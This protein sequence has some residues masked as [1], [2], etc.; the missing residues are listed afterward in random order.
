[1]SIETVLGLFSRSVRTLIISVAFEAEK[2]L[3]S[4]RTLGRFMSVRC[5]RHAGPYGPEDTFF[6]R[7]RMRGTG[8]RTTVKGGMFGEP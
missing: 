4:S 1:M 8:P 2:R 3:R 5:Y 6:R 7:Q